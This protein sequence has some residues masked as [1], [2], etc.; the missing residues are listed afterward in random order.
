M[1]PSKLFS[2]TAKLFLAL[3]LVSCLLLS[4]CG[5][6]AE[7]GADDAD[8]SKPPLVLADVSW[9]SIK[10]HNRI[11]GF[12]IE[13]GYGYPEPKY[14]FGD[15]LPMLQGLA[16]GDVDIY[17]EIWADNIKE[18]WEEVLAEGSVKNLGPNLPD[19]PQG[20]WVPTYMIEGDPER[21]IEAMTPDLKTVQDLPKYWELFKD[22]EAP[23][24]GR[25]HNSPP[26]W[27]CTSINEVKMKTYGLEDTYNVFSTGSDAALVTS[28]VTAYE[29]GE[30]WFG[31]YWEPTW[32]MG[33]LDMTMLEEPPYDEAVWND[34]NNRGCA[35]PPAQVL[36]GINSGLEEKAPELIEFLDNYQTTLAQ[37]NDFLAYMDDY[38]GDNS[39]EAAAI[40]F[41]ETYPEVWK[42][43]L[44]EDIVAKVE[45]ALNEVE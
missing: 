38:E 16:K 15:T 5:Q 37:N 24:K 42:S 1:L 17:L 33:K 31:Y 3:L 40:Y 32:V 10:V 9:D 2:K 21:G 4:G 14:I 44:P 25:F 7:S 27:I 8:V 41:F 26:G 12:I 36:V 11:A 20:W 18:A 45:N 43:W 29:K 35:Y 34:E 23:T 6:Q 39:E 13:H 22:P 19:G 30:P 28:M